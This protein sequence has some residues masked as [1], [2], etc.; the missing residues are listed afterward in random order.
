ME[1]YIFS[2]YNI[3]YIDCTG[4]YNNTLNKINDLHIYKPSSRD[5][6]KLIFHFII[7]D[8]LY[9]SKIKKTKEKPVFFFRSNDF[10]K[11]DTTFIVQFINVVKMLKKLLPVPVLIF[12][13]EEI[14]KKNNGNLKGL[15][16]KI[17]NFYSTRDHSTKKL[18]K[19]LEVEEYYEL[20]KVLGEVRS[21]KTLVN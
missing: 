9:T 6:K 13:D 2:R 8:L 17:F 1:D 12:K 14:F 19:Y 18:R 11:T 4:F 20:I 7:R 16:E 15:S 10:L 21:L 5:I 3:V